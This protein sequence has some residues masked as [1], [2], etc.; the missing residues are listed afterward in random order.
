MTKD[1]NPSSTAVQDRASCRPISTVLTGAD[2]T[3]AVT[4]VRYLEGQLFDDRGHVRRGLTPARADEIAALING[5]R[6]ALGWLEIGMDGQWR[7]PATLL[8][9]Q[10]IC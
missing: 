5:L 6:Q 9:T 4:R 8:R 3:A 7:W 10:F 1:I 2:K